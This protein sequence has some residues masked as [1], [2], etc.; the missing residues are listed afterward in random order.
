VI[1]DRA[2]LERLGKL[3]RQGYADAMPLRLRSL[4]ALIAMTLLC[5]V[6]VGG[7]ARADELPVC[8][9]GPGKLKPVVEKRAGKKIVE[10]SLRGN[11]RDAR[12]IFY[13]PTGHKKEQSTYCNGVRHGAVTF[14]YDDG[15]PELEGAFNMGA[16][17]GTWTFRTREGAR[18]TFRPLPKK[19]K[20]GFFYDEGNRA[21][22]R[23]EL[24]LAE[25][26]LQIAL[27]TSHDVA[28]VHRSLGV[29]YAK[30][31]Q[32]AR[33]A[34]HYRTYIQ[35]APNAKDREQVEQILAVY[36]RPPEAEPEPK[37]PAPAPA[38]TPAPQP[39]APAPTPTPAPTPAPAPSV[40]YRLE[41]IT[42]PAASVVV[43]G[44]R[45]SFLTPLDGP[46]ALHLAPGRHKIVLEVATEPSTIQHLEVNLEADDPNNR[47]EFVP[48][49]RLTTYGAVKI[50]P[51]AP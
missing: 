44:K 51:L 5:G 31:R 7:Q 35:Q 19:R 21:L 42:L 49:E 47:I 14:W 39:V 24:A 4:P 37:A 1:D 46:R 22:A 40:T 45:H 13:W 18:R 50:R 25:S 11:K 12:W 29:L 20:R 38:P 9:P 23:H 32:P 3:R 10:G 28:K 41:I 48:G 8:K 6:F 15:L 2:V 17:W 26:L 27:R 36:A 30:Q 16:P 43:D 34:F 33:A